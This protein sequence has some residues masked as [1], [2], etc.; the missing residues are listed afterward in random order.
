MILRLYKI[1]SSVVSAPEWMKE[2]LR[3]LAGMMQLLRKAIV[4][5]KL[6]NGGK[7][8][9]FEVFVQGRDAGRVTCKCSFSY[10][11]VFHTRELHGT[12]GGELNAF[13][14]NGRGQ[15]MNPRIYSGSCCAKACKPLA[16]GTHVY[17]RGG[18]YT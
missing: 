18:G 5:L 17:Y 14:K 10:G 11:F 9:V 3:S 13:F 4:L 6:Q 1:D 12:T 16:K 7:V 15:E 8:P 2:S